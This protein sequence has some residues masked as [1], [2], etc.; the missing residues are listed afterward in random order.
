MVKLVYETNGGQKFDTHKAAAEAEKLEV[1]AA[2]LTEHFNSEL[3]FGGPVAGRDIAVWLVKRYKLIPKEDDEEKL[4][5]AF[6]QLADDLHSSTSCS[7]IQA[8]ELAE[9]LLRH[10]AIC[11]K[12]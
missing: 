10:H 11:R 12:A 4:D 1:E 5:A 6:K 8:N 9:W 2:A 3:F 7:V